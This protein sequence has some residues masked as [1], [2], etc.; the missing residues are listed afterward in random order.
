[1]AKSEKEKKDHQGVLI[2]EFLKK[3]DELKGLVLNKA[4]IS[5]SENS[6]LRYC[7]SLV[8]NLIK[9]IRR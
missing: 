1:M 6:T 2:K 4:L 7:L 5:K 8:G 3:I 9:I